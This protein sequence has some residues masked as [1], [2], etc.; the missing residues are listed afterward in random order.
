M[1]F[2]YFTSSV[3]AACAHVCDQPASSLAHNSGAQPVQGNRKQS[4][5]KA[6]QCSLQSYYY[7]C[8]TFKLCTPVQGDLVSRAQTC[9]NKPPAD[10]QSITV[11]AAAVDKNVAARH[12][13]FKYE[14]TRDTSRRTH[15]TRH[16]AQQS[17]ACLAQTTDFQF[18]L[19]V[20]LQ[21][22]HLKRLFKF[23]DALLEVSQ[24]KVCTGQHTPGNVITTL[25]SHE[26]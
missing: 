6:Q 26:M 13:S 10:I 8:P 23:T 5:Q 12:Q 16:T 2:C 9:Q 18:F 22:E 19:R 11:H 7:T 25:L 1:V 4:Y 17:Q 14:P 3:I 20:S 21:Q 24:Y 15:E